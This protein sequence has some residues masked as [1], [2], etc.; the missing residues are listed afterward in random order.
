[1]GLPMAAL[2][3]NRRLSQISTQ[4]RVE[5]MKRQESNFDAFGWRSV[6]ADTR[7]DASNRPI[8]SRHRSRSASDLQVAPRDAVRDEY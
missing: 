6:N 8:E 2:S 7:F 5:G 1:M 4:Q 3:H